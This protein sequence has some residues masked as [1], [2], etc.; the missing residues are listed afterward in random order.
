MRIH[1]LYDKAIAAVDKVTLR[2]ICIGRDLKATPPSTDP[3]SCDIRERV[4]TALRNHID[5]CE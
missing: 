1:S 4:G 5:R 2:V 3:L